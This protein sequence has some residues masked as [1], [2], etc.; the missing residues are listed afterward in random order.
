MS[1]LAEYA[2]RLHESERRV[3]P[4][5]LTPLRLGCA[6]DTLKGVRAV[7]VD[8]YGTMVNYWR[9]GFE[10]RDSR[11][12]LLVE[13]FSGVVDRFG[14]GETLAAMNPAEPPAKTLFGFYHGLLA[15]NRQKSAGEGT[16]Q[17]EVRVE[18]VWSVIAL[19]LKR[20]G[21]DAD[22]HAPWRGDPADFARCL[23]YTYN[24]LSMGRELYPGAANA[25]KRLKDS[26]MALGILSDAQF[27]TPV[28]LTLMLRDQSDGK[29]VD[30]GELF[31]T[32]LTFLSCEYGFV[33]PGEVLYR[34]LFDA[35]YEYR[36]TPEQTVVVGND[37]MTDIAPAVALGM[38]TAL[39]CG[40][41]AMVFGRDGQ[42]DGD[43]VLPDMVFYEWEEL[44]DR[45][46][47]HGETG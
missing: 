9:P 35:L 12:A 7:I 34:R 27:Y 20:N 43:C 36:I 24:F 46:L 29:V 31:D 8:V 44:P 32:D 19:M 40:D 14:M 6:V 42:G 22:V 25:L 16:A 33:K 15:L 26:N 47:F 38:R 28:D 45:L 30:Y 39:F 23:A 13:A 11:E 37:L 21:Y 10:E 41:D 5:R 3:Y 17:P 18:E 1:D 4:R 2:R